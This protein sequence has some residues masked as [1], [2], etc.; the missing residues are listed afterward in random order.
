[1]RMG[2]IR[3]ENSKKYCSDTRKA[4]VECR[5]TYRFVVRGDEGSGGD[6][7]KTGYLKEF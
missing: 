1:M 4:E 6:A 2:R 7:Q 5:D 3:D